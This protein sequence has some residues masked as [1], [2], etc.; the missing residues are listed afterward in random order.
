MNITHEITQD[1]QAVITIQVEPERLREAMQQAARLIAQRTKIPGFRPGR[2]PY[3]VIAARIGQETLREEALDHLGHELYEQALK[4]VGLEPIAPGKIE[5]V[6][7]E[8]LTF[9]ATVPLA[10]LVELGDYHSIRIPP[11]EVQVAEAQVDEILQNIQADNAEVVPVEQPAAV[12]DQLVADIHVTT[13]GQTIGDQQDI[14]FILNPNAVRNMPPGFLDQVI[15]MR[16]GESREF[17]LAYPADH[18]NSDLAGKTAH[19]QITVHEVKERQL[20]PLD[21]EL[22]KTVGD[23]ESLE[24]LRQHIREDLRA[25]AQREADER[26]KEAVLQAVIDRST[27]QFPPIL[28]ERELDQMLEEQDQAL[29]A[30][31]LNL[32]RALNLEHKTREQLRNELR[33][34]AERRVKRSLILG[35]IVKRENIEVTP[36]ETEQANLSAGHLLAQKAINRLVSIARGEESTES[37]K[38]EG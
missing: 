6:E 8:P 14:T 37:E 32:E 2:A 33:E 3:Q 15:G 27:V 13:D 21:D 24:A 30:R 18:P 1:R 17:D 25:R 35:E 11:E 29:K 26:Y 38:A 31:G 10:P 19:C 4:D 22:A 34:V 5:V 36:Q 7:Q 23:F 20:P 9:Q 12:G 28:I 16:A